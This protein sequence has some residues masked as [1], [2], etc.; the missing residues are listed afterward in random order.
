MRWRG[1][2]AAGGEGRGQA[3]KRRPT[4][5]LAPGLAVGGGE[6]VLGGTGG[7]G[8]KI[9]VVI[10]EA[11]LGAGVLGG[12]YV[13]K[14]GPLSKVRGAFPQRRVFVFEAQTGRLREV[15]R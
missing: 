5:G 9:D 11:T 8:G 3:K 14:V 12:R 7:G 1:L 10:N 2:G 15:R 4:A 6:G 13:P